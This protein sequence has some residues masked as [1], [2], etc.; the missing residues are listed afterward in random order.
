MASLLVIV[1]QE[2][3]DGGLR[4]A[5]EASAFWVGNFLRQRRIFP[6]IAVH[7]VTRTNHNL[8]RE[9]AGR[10]LCHIYG[11]EP[12]VQMVHPYPGDLNLPQIIT[13]ARV[14][15][16][17]ASTIVFVGNNLSQL[18]GMLARHKPK[19]FGAV[20]FEPP[21]F[22]LLRFAPPGKKA[23]S[24]DFCGFEYHRQRQDLVVEFWKTAVRFEEQ[25]CPEC[26]SYLEFEHGGALCLKCNYSKFA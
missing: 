2:Q 13:A 18:R 14:K 3:R 17:G 20:L 19:R 5:E 8:A 4:E 21:G 15:T 23:R 26:G 7:P 10:L 22:V 12:E 16:P 1:Y 9:M 25:E 11:K 6:D 24:F